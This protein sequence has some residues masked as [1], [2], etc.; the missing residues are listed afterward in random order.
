MA[1]EPAESGESVS[2]ESVSG[3]STSGHSTSRESAS[4]QSTPAESTAGADGGEKRVE[5][6]PQVNG[7]P[8]KP[9]AKRRAGSKQKASGAEGASSADPNRLSPTINSTNPVFGVP[10]LKHFISYSRVTHALE[11]YVLAALRENRRLDHILIHGRPG[12]GTTVL[13][14]ALARDYAPERFEEFDAQGGI[15]YPRLK[16]A[17]I[18]ANRRGVVLIRHIELLDPQNA[19]LVSAYLAGKQIERDD[20]TPQAH[21]QRPPWESELDREIADSARTRDGEERKTAPITPGGTIIG[22]ALVPMQINY[23]MRG[24]FEQMVHLRSDPKALRAT[25]VR[26]MKPHRVTIDPACYP[27]LERVLGTLTDGTEQLARTLLARA[28]M[29]GHPY[30]N[31]ELMKSIVE[32]DLPTRLPDAHY[33]AAL[34]EHLAGR[35]VREASPGEVERIAHETQW[36]AMAAHAA[37]AAMVRENRSRK[38]SELPPMPL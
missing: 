30:I 28:A 24:K 26:A 12:T 15:S 37:I 18:K 34:R 17:L 6:E 7:E 29:E 23:S 5:R 19:A 33:A 20:G 27:R 31:D 14:R 35:K 11:G 3:D 21:R 2:G 4:G 36:G 13:A 8:V 1:E 25:L 16:R 10:T 32:E 38:R 9:T 22:T